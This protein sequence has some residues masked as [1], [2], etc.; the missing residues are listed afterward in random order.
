MGRPRTKPAP[1]ELR[2]GTRTTALVDLV[3][4]GVPSEH[5]R[6][7]YRRSISDLEAFADGRPLS[8]MLLLEWRA[9]LAETRSSA[10]VNLRLAAARALMRE[11][12][13]AGRLTG[14]E[15]MDLLDVAG[16]PER[17]TKVGN[18]LTVPQVRRLL[19]VH[20]GKTLRPRRNRCILALLIGCG[21][22]RNELVDLTCD[23][24]VSRDGRWV[25][26]DL[27]SKGGRFRTVA[28]PEWTVSA[29]NAWK[30]VSKIRDGLLIR[31]LTLKPNGLSE[32]T[33]R[34]IVYKAAQ[35]A[36]LPKISPHDLRRTCAKLCRASGATVEQIQIML[37]HASI[38]TTERYLGTVQDLRS[39]PND[40][41]GIM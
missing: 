19:D 37:G 25:L 5:T 41:M 8:R 29:I 16:L 40:N 34:K 32:D 7:S 3:L 39:A 15:L 24:I 33:V 21:L 14:D 1:G 4:A 22:R 26:A 9:S 10:T 2:L 30:Q 35:T 38:Q 6:R 13:K 18:W 36:R 31:Q 12:R 28:I 20:N 27:P 11:A 23:R 17:G